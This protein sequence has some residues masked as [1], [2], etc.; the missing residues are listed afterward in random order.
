MLRDELERG[1]RMRVPE[2][3]Q[4]QPQP[5]LHEASPGLAAAS[6]RGGVNVGGASVH[7]PRAAPLA[8]PILRDSF[9]V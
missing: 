9:W 2:Q 6:A 8:Q 3:P 1:G 4:P 5:R 7:S